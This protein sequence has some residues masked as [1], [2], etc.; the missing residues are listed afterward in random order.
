MVEHD[1]LVQVLDRVELDA[2][3]VLHV[4][5]A[6]RPRR[7]DVGNLRGSEGSTSQLTQVRWPSWI[8]QLTRHLTKLDSQMKSAP[9]LGADNEPCKVCPVKIASSD[10]TRV[11]QFNE[12]PI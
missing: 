4:R 11:R 8:F 10:L 3:H 5:H 9:D 2:A 6:R 1:G 7:G 12:N